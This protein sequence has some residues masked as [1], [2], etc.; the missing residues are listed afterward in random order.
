MQT[1]CDAAFPL[2]KACLYVEAELHHV[3]VAHGV[4]FSFD[5]ELACLAA[6]AHGAEGYEVVEV[7]DFGGDESALEVGVDDS[8]GGGCFSHVR[9]VS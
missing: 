7:D 1:I 4:F 6:F 5:A 3:A 9:N 2:W 8:C